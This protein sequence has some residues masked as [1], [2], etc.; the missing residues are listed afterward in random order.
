MAHFRSLLAGAA[1]LVT[2]IC[3]ALSSPIN[4]QQDEKFHIASI[5]CADGFDHQ[6]EYQG[7]SEKNLEMVLLKTNLCTPANTTGTVYKRILISRT[8]DNCRFLYE[9]NEPL[10][11]MS[12]SPNF[13]YETN[14]QI[15]T[16]ILPGHTPTFYYKTLNQFEGDNA[17]R[18]VIR[19]RFI[20]SLLFVLLLTVFL[21][22]GKK[23][24]RESAL[25]G[26]LFTFIPHG[27]F[28]ISSVSNS[29]WSYAGCS[30]SWAF[31]YIILNQPVQFNLTSFLTILGWIIT[32]GITVLSRFDAVIYLIISNL[33]ILIFTL[34]SQ[35]KRPNKRLYFLLAGFPAVAAV[36]LSSSSGL[37][38]LTR[39]DL[40][41]D[42]LFELPIVLGNSIKLAI[43]TPLRILGLQAP[44]WGPVQA[45]SP[46]VLINL[47]FFGYLSYLF[48]R[49]NNKAQ[50]ITRSV[51]LGSLFAVYFFQ[52]FTQRN[53][54]TP[55]YLIRT[56][57]VSDDFSPR[58]FI[59]YFPF[60]FG[61][62]ALTSDKFSKFF[63]IRKFKIVLLGV[64]FV[65][66]AI[67]LYN[68]GETFRG[69][70]SWYWTNFL[71]S[72][73]T[74]FISGV[75]SFFFFLYFVIFPSSKK[76]SVNF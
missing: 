4:S 18:S 69:N 28:L 56:S 7:I 2:L 30:F 57:W 16:W 13:F 34:C 10:K 6:C 19:F 74:L 40:K 8:T 73:N 43:A 32:S 3:W 37:R 31:F 49:T 48:L 61:I 12:A 41:L 14:T 1:L 24:I 68:I 36:G 60:L 63:V 9:I 52:C 72:V 20:N 47:T 22:V 66:Q 76:R 51:S 75:I 38:R 45:S 25:I 50:S 53:W 23:A 70:P 26:L 46:V 33:A 64:L 67:T 58:Y 55:F 17:E 39:L 5:L 65:T 44:G 27:L 59:P 15:A 11:T 21:I 62:L 35:T 71:I 29:S 42:D 54:T